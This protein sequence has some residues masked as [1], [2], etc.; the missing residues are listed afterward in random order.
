[1]NRAYLPAETF[2]LYDGLWKDGVAEDNGMRA[3]TAHVDF[4]WSWTYRDRSAGGL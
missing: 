1:L 2:T 3:Y 4:G